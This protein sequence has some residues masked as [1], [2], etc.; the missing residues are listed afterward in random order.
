[1]TAHVARLEAEDTGVLAAQSLQ[2]GGVRRLAQRATDSA[3]GRA[4]PQV[5]QG[6]R[7]APAKGA[8]ARDALSVPEI[9]PAAAYR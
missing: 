3:S 1:V 2:G 6:R 8:G 4:A 7:G 9:R 5:A